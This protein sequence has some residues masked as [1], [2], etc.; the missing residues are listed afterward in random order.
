M[1]IRCNPSP[2]ILHKQQICIKQIIFGLISEELKSFVQFCPIDF[3]G[4]N[5]LTETALSMFLGKLWS[6]LEKSLISLIC[7]PLEYE[8]EYK[9]FYNLDFLSMSTI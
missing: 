7:T 8:Y 2:F 9:K 1:H 4:N 5:F 3:V 6:L